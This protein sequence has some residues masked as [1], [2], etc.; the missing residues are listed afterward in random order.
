[1]SVSIG[2]SVTI[3]VLPPDQNLFA[4]SVPFGKIGAQFSYPHYGQ[5]GKIFPRI[6]GYNDQNEYYWCTRNINADNSEVVL[7][8]NNISYETTP[9]GHPVDPLIV[10]ENFDSKNPKDFYVLMMSEEPFTESDLPDKRYILVK[11]RGI[12]TRTIEECGDFVVLIVNDVPTLVFQA[13][14]DKDMFY[15]NIN[16]VYSKHQF[17]KNMKNKKY[18]IT[19]AIKHTINEL[20]FPPIVQPR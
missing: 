6:Q 2:N 3:R 15:K 1:M 8:S 18:V 12:S 13:Y 14:L 10:D 9:G 7:T 19:N 16:S 4:P 20:V 17:I 11:G 5:N